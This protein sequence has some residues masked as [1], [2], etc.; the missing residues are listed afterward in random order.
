MPVPSPHYGREL[1]IS[2]VAVGRHQ[3]L[4]WSLIHLMIVLCL[5]KKSE[6]VYT[7]K[8][9]T[10][11]GNNVFGKSV[12]AIV[13][14]FSGSFTYVGSQSLADTARGELLYSTHCIACH[15]TQVH[16]RDKKLVTDQTSLQGEV[17]RWQ[18]VLGLEWRTDDI[19]DVTQYLNA[20]YYHYPLRTEGSEKNNREQ[21]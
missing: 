16:W 20:S 15:R 19:E 13:L 8:M 21:E 18:K 7:H 2:I 4:T 5:W 9:E 1:I 6:A 17:R 10:L 3:P 12:L 14:I 11:R